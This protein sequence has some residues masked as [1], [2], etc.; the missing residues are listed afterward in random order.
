MKMNGILWATLSATLLVTLPSGAQR[1]EKAEK[2]VG[3]TVTDSRNQHVGKV[4]ELAVDM[5]A[6]RIAEVLVDTGGFLTSNHRVVAVPPELFSFADFNGELL[7]NADLDAFDGAPIF[8]MSTWADSTRSAGVIDAYK[9]FHVQPYRG[10]SHLEQAGRIIGLAVRNPRN[11]H[12]GTIE[13]LVVSLPG[14]QIPD[15][16]I[17]SPTFLGLKDEWTAVPP[18][19]FLF[20]IGQNALI[21]ETTGEAFKNAP[22]FKASDWKEAVNGSLNASAGQDTEVSASDA[23]VTLDIERKI[24]SVE[25][26]SIDVREVRVVTRQGRVTLYGTADSEKEK[27]QL[28]AIAASVVPADHVD[29]KIEVKLY[30]FA[31]PH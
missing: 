1:L 10:L 28:G 23:A 18:Q 2:I 29:N 31:A 25:G 15:V 17:G 24:Q 20:D 27:Q 21:L 7:L 3:L 6:G 11:Q 9:R 16:M 8:D 14:G 13:T 30:A 22:H 26:L 19:A 4:R 12:L 5:Q